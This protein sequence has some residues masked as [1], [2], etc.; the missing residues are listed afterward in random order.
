MHLPFIKKPIHVLLLLS[1]ICCALLVRRLW[2]AQNLEYSF[3][4]W[5][6]FL[7][8]VPLLIMR[9]VRSHQPMLPNRRVFVFGGMLCWLLFFPNAPYIITDL[10][11]LRYRTGVPLWYDSLMVFSF[12]SVGLY[13]GLYSLLL[14]HRL[15]DE[16]FGRALSWALLAG[17]LGLSGFGIYLGRFGRWNSWDLLTRPHRLIW[18]ALH[19]LL[20]P[21]AI[22]LTLAFGLMLGLFYFVFLSFMQLSAHE[23][24][25]KP[26]GE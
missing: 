9:F 4:A 10:M 26:D 12:A 11:H 24:K 22:K 15:L 1:G 19:Q 5:N 6:L 16:L 14:A 20:N 25:Y 13:T 7:A 21:T 3:M 23:A 17:A 8:W 18:D 2:A